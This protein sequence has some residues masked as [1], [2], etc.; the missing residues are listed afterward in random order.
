MDVLG[1]DVGKKDLHAVLLQGETTARKS[2]PNTEKGFAQLAAW[3]A[4]RGAHKL[5]ACLEAT[6]I[7]GEAIAEFL[8][9]S[10]HIVSV[11]NPGQ[12]KAYGR[13]ELT[14]TKTDAVDAGVIARFC[15]ANHPAPW[16]PPPRE[17]RVLRALIRRRETLS[18]MITQELN[19]LESAT[20]DQV[21]RSIEAVL[22]ALKGELRQVEK[23]LDE[24]LNSHPDLRGQVEQLDAI[25]GFGSL[26]AMKV[27]AETNGFTVCSNAK[28]IVAFAGL[29]PTLYESG[30]IRRRGRISKIGNAA[31]RK[32]L[33]YAALSNL[34]R[35]GVYFGPF[36]DRLKTAGKR[37][38]VIITALMRKL[39]V[40]AFTLFKSR[41]A[42]DPAYCA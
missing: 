22:K 28:E 35:H 12:I 42:F 40:L 8:H 39:L 16:N 31:L 4:N 25:P 36:I 3:L 5:H 41:R 37:P 23:L 21:R 14:R 20:T 13:S 29:N 24:H 38:K 10:G 2:V 9:D 26:T 11:V 27:I 17:M 1:I 18:N 15:R 33:F 34:R 6:G 19:R 30:S 7:Y 32:A